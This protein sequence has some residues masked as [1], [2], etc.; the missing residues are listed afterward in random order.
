MM[1]NALHNYRGAG[2]YE[3]DYYE[4]GYE[5]PECSKRNGELEEVGLL[6]RDLLKIIYHDRVTNCK[7]LEWTLEEMCSR[8]NVKYEDYGVQYLEVIKQRGEIYG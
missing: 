5:C 4:T 8:L 3:P 6:M 1:M 7:D 2:D